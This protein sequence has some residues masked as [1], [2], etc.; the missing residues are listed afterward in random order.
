MVEHEL[1][2]AISMDELDYIFACN[3]VG[4]QVLFLLVSKSYL[5]SC[6]Y[7]NCSFKIPLQIFTYEYCK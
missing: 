7:L 5:L 4:L 2:I 6:T 3:R 1:V